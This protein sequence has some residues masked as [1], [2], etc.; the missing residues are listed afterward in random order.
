M[1]V[2]E[3]IDHLWEKRQD[4]TV[5]ILT[6]HWERPVIGIIEFE[7]ICAMYANEDTSP[8][9]AYEKLVS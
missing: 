4:S 1:T 6:E 5:T 7:G 3:L 8:I 9:E 2:K